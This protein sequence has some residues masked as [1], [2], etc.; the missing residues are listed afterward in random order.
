[1]KRSL[2]FGITGQDGSYLAEELLEQGHAVYGVVRRSSV[3]NTA[4]I[5]H[6]LN[7]PNLILLRGDLLDAH[8]VDDAVAYARPDA[9]YNVADQ[10][11]VR[12]SEDTPCYSY[13]ITF[14]AVGTILE[15]VKKRC[16]AAMVFQP[17][18][19]TM[20]GGDEDQKNEYASVQPRSPYAC[21]KTGAYH[22]TNMYRNQY[23]LNILTGIMFNHDSPRRGSGYLLHK[24]ADKTIDVREGRTDTIT[25]YNPSFRVDIGHAQE[26]M[27]CIISLMESRII[28]NYVVGTG[29][30]YTVSY[31]VTHAARKLQV[32]LDKITWE[33]GGDEP[34]LIACPDKLKRC[35]SDF[36]LAGAVDV[37]DQIIAAKTK[38]I[39][40]V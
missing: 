18:S 14:G 7:H 15:S 22:L 4:R 25:M 29:V 28:G 10:D 39:K 11:D 26:Y 32:S 20:F 1:M 5:S 33:P 34:E 30:P 38:G 24:I 8:S 16:P 21:A 37:L 13:A 17:V 19:A 27:R 3:D 6:L 40:C 36:P 12:W 23:K 31:L 9:V 2:I 35:V